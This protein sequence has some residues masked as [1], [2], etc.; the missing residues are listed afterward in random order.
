[1]NSKRYCVEFDDRVSEQ[2]ETIARDTA[3]IPPEEL[4]A[5]L[6]VKQLAPWHNLASKEN[7]NE[8]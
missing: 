4:I 2:I 1:M 8:G 3:K 7:I 5:L 6:V